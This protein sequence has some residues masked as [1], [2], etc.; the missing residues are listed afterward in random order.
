MSKTRKRV[1]QKPNVLKAKS[2][3]GIPQEQGQAVVSCCSNQTSSHLGLRRQKL[4]T[5]RTLG[6]RCRKRGVTLH[7]TILSRLSQQML[8]NEAKGINIET[9]NGKKPKRKC[10]IIDLTEGIDH[11]SHSSEEDKLSKV[12]QKQRLRK[13]V[14][15]PIRSLPSNSEDKSC[16]N[17][18]SFSELNSMSDSFV[19][20]H[21]S[22]DE[23][24]SCTMPN[25]SSAASDIHLPV[26]SVELEPM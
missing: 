19:V 17:D 6:R 5:H 16:D 9:H 10:I 24:E 14:L 13:K 18:A 20:L 22:S 7:S 8:K 2:V 26:Q 12:M 11:K 23:L 4:R 25:V 1:E 3:A 21:S 15:Q